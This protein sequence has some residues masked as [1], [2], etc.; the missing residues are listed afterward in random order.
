PALAMLAALILLVALAHALD[1][2]VWNWLKPAD[3]AA[4]ERLERSDLY[5]LFRVVGY[6]PTWIVLAVAVALALPGQGDRRLRAGLA[7][8]LAAAGAGGLAEVAKLVIARERP[9]LAGEYIYRGLFAGFRDGANLGMPSSHA[10]VAFGAAFGV[11]AALPRAAPIAMLCAAGCALTRLLS[12]AHFLSDCVGALLLG[13][14]AARAVAR[15]VK[16]VPF[17]R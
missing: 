14:L 13:W 10:A 1:G 17:R 3:G 15:V 5:R 9:G 11:A 4:L 2:A 8:G 7:V 16:P 12:G 6:L